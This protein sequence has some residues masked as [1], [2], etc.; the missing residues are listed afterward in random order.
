MAQDLSSR[1]TRLEELLACFH[2]A[3]GHELPNQMIALQGLLRL[4]ELDD[5]ERLSPE[6]REYLHRLQTAAQRTHRQ[7]R[8]LAELS[9]AA[10]E[11]QPVER[12]SVLD[13][14]RE[15]SV[16]INR[17]YPGLGIGYHFPR[18]VPFLNVAR[19][20]L[21]QVLVQLVRHAALVPGKEPPPRLEIGVDAT[22][23]AVTVWVQ[24]PDGRARLEQLQSWLVPFS[25]TTISNAELGLGLF[26]ARQ[27]VES[28]GGS[29]QVQSAPEQGCTLSIVVANCPVVSPRSP[30]ARG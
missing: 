22:E 26:L 7:V 30:E 11:V 28:W 20:A 4:L 14:V 2:Q 29:L 1:L 19:S 25:P 12:I 21:H 24:N 27:I 10:R 15:A 23:D 9:R 17:L 16:E 5:G 6:G 3:L 13:A 8:A 18:T